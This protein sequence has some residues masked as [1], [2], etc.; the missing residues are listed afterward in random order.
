MTILT[1]G[2]V[3]PKLCHSSDKKSKV[4]INKEFLDLLDE[5]SVSGTC[6]GRSYSINSTTSPLR[7]LKR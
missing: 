7:V 1:D 3:R 5:E 4:C 6:S 2:C